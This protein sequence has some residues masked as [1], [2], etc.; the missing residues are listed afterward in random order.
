MEIEF[1]YQAARSLEVQSE[2]AEFV[3]GRSTSLEG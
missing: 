3:S 2:M 1:F